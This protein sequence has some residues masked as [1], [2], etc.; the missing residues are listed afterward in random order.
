MSCSDIWDGDRQE[1]PKARRKRKLRVATWNSCH[2]RN[3]QSLGDLVST[4][5]ITVTSTCNSWRESD[6]ETCKVG[7]IPNCECLQWPENSD[8][9]VIREK[10]IQKIS[11]N[12]LQNNSTITINFVIYYICIHTHIIHTY[13][14]TC[15]FVAT[16]ELFYWWNNFSTFI[17]IRNNT[18]SSKV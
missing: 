8:E 6:S 18:E 13:I 10:C 9:Q 11:A 7:A 1:V 14:Y 3:P 15:F 17:N 2:M 4:S 12:F 16:L 5:T